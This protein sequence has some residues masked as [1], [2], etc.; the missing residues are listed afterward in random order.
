MSPLMK[1][2]AGEMRKLEH[3]FR[4][5]KL[6]HIPRGQDTIVKEM[7]QI[8]TKGLPVPARIFVK[9]LSKP[10][11]VSKE[12]EVAGALS[13]STLGLPRQA[14]H[15]KMQ[16]SRQVRGALRLLPLADPAKG[17]RFERGRVL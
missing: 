10:S 5:L 2:Y 11:A 13:T 14:C 15:K 8:A 7:S 16:M 1:A 12:E 9:R 6:E 3:C 4:S 17:Y